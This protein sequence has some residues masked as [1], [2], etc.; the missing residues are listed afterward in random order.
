MEISTLNELWH[1]VIGT[2]PDPPTWLV[3]GT[4]V[5]AL[6]AVAYDP[7]WRVCRTIVTIAHEGG[8]AIAAVCSGRRL[9]GIRLHSDTSGLTLSRGKP[10]GA[11]MVV[12]AAAGYVAPPILG[13]GAAWLLAAG[14]VTALLWL[15]VALLAAMLVMIRNA[16]G[17]MAVLATGAG[18]FA[19]SWLAT[20]IVQAAVAYFITWLLLL[21]GA[22]PVSELQ[23]KRRRGR[24]PNSDADQ[25]ARL[26]RLPGLLWVGAFGAV[27]IAGLLLG[28]AL[29]VSD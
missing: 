13:L 12:T 26:T 27:A 24:A 3:V 29:L 11:G 2:Q 17:V 5:V 14:H 21:A 25:L 22:R 10:R 16:Y 23:R 28:A 4:G 9:R 8:H 18:A 15:V 20:T 7:A 1:R 19:V 6:L